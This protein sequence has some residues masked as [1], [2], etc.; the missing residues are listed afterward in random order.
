VLAVL[1]GLGSAYVAIQQAGSAD[2]SVTNGAWY[3]DLTAGG[4]DAGMH[5]RARVAVLGLLA[6]N[7]HETI[8]YTARTDSAGERLSGACSYRIEGRDPDAR[9]WSITAYASDNFLIDN[10]GNRYSVSKNTVVRGPDGSFVI[11]LSLEPEAHNAIATSPD[12]FDVTLRLYNPG[13]TVLKD[14]SGVPLPVIVKEA[15]S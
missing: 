12:G 6:L 5:T 8:Y 11:R 1:L 13:P 7:K 9:W 4:A 10:P 14:P 3:A 15:C 2:G